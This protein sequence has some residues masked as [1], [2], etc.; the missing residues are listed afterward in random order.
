MLRI[1]GLGFVGLVSGPG[2]REYGD[3]RIEAVRGLIC[4]CGASVSGRLEQ[5]RER[6]TAAGAHAMP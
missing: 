2:V 6:W 3:E 5:S 4:C 1:R